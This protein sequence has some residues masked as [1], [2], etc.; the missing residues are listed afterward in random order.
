MSSYGLQPVLYGF[1]WVLEAPCSFLALFSLAQCWTRP[2]S[3]S[4]S[5]L[6]L[7]KGTEC[8]PLGCLFLRV[9]RVAHQPT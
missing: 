5:V 8:L 1:I 4:T 3:V 6:Q 2:G 9:P 7:G